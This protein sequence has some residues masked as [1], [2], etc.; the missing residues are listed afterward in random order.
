M[1]PPRAQ[2]RAFRASARPR[3]LVK[4]G[5]DDVNEHLV[6]GKDSMRQRMGWRWPRPR[7]VRSSLIG[8]LPV[9]DLQHVVAMPVDVLFVL[10]EL[11]AQ[12]LLEVRTDARES[13]H[14]VH[15]IPRQVES[16]QIVQHRH[17]KG[18]RCGALLLVPPDME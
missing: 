17:I 4:R 1:P 11:V 16:V 13:R 6:A 5:I 15:Y 2:P 8:P 14:A 18:G 9:A 7:D 3:V 10:E 12:V